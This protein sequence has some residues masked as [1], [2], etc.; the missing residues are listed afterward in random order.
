QPTALGLT[1]LHIQR[2]EPH[3]RGVFACDLFDHIEG[4]GGDAAGGDDDVVAGSE[5]VQKAAEG[6]GVVPNL[7]NAGGDPG[8]QGLGELGGHRAVGVWD[9]GE[10]AVCR[11]CPSAVGLSTVS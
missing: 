1:R 2:A 9:A 4:S 7:V 5:F 6:V 8:A 11:C 3:V 10:S